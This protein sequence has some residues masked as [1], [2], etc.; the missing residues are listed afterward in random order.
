MPSTAVPLRVRLANWLVPENRP[1][2]PFRARLA[3]RLLAEVHPVTPRPGWRF[4]V[5]WDMPEPALRLRRRIWTKC[6]QQG[7][8]V[9]LVV[10]WFQGLKIRLHLPNDLS[11]QVFVA[12]SF[13]PNELFLLE[14]IL[15]PGMIFLDVGANEGIF[16]LFAAAR[17]GPAGTVWAFEPSRREFLRLSCNVRLN[18]LP[19]VRLFQLALSAQDG[20]GDLIVAEP[21]HA[22]HNTLGGFAH[23]GVREFTRERVPL[24]RLDDLLVQEGLLRVDVLKIDVEGAETKVVRGAEKTL[25]DSRP[26]VLFEVLEE[27]LNLQGSSSTELIGLLTSFG[28]RL[29]QFDRQTGLPVLFDQ[30]QPPNNMVAVPEEHPPLRL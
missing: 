27:A 9:S 21:E 24:R 8:E 7:L 2:T 29:Y 23:A 6:R 14:K 26:I 13:E 12:G 5:D 17:V 4:D 19:N 22:G 25:R 10:P 20:A 3:A 18:R 15:R 28:Y 1:L 11:K 30:E 16:A